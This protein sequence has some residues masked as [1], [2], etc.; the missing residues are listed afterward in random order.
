M[1]SVAGQRIFPALATLWWRCAAVFHDDGVPRD[2]RLRR[3]VALQLWVLAGVALLGSFFG[4]AIAVAGLSALYL[5]V[6]LIG[7]IFVLRDFRIGVVLLVLLL[8]I[9]RSYVFPHAMLGITGLN[10]FNLLLIG[11]LGAYL[12]HGMFDGSLRRFLPRPLLWLYI[13]P[14]LV[15]GVLGSRHLGDIPP[16]LIKGLVEFDSVTGYFRD[17]VVKP[18]LMVIFALLV[19]AAVSKS[20]KPERFLAPTLISMWVMVSIVFVFV[21]L[22]GISLTEMASSESRE[23]L[24]ALG[25]HANELGR[26]Y[27]TAYAL[28][29]FTWFRSKNPGFRLAL[30][31]SIGLVTVALVLTFSRGAYLGFVLI[32]ALFLIWHRNAR[33]LLL[34]GLLALGV[35][36]LLPEAVYDRVTTGFGNDS[37]DPVAISAG[38]IEYIWLPLLPEIPKS[39]IFGHGLGSILWSEPM[40]RGAGTTILAV[41]HPH[42]AY[43]GALLDMGIVGLVLLCAYF[44]H[45][46]KGFRA[47][48]VDPALNPTL[49][50]FYAGA[51]AG[52]A[53]LLISYVTDS[54]LTPGPE[55]SFLWLAIGMMYGQRAG[56]AV[57]EP[58]RS[59]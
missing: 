55:Q 35:L 9:S 33:T 27:A 37:A 7:C 42:N 8:P 53:S 41:G 22:S 51:A 23:F 32:N 31:A 47:L 11:T 54:S 44:A 43:L 17:L 50:G 39:P 56:A 1:S 29:L 48:T 58:G 57:Q 10:P 40:R 14:I 36:I 19:G 18:L 30:M 46:W 3:R 24:S 12:L 6:S 49:Q 2:A 21:L 26:L 45:V 38:R 5:C 52:L 34:F 13:V 59:S 4:F 15:A 20:E 28:L 25:M 16:F